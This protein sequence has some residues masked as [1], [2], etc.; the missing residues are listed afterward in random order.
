MDNTSEELNATAQVQEASVVDE[1]SAADQKPQEEQKPAV[2][3]L[4]PGVEI[5]V[6]GEV[7]RHATVVRDDAA[8]PFAAVRYPDGTVEKV[9]HKRISRV[10]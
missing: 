6:R 3:L 10:A 5:V 8:S 2:T 7:N 4:P 9:H 1:K